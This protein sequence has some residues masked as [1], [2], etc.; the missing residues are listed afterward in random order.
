MVSGTR[1]QLA[2][3]IVVIIVCVAAIA[4][5]SQPSSGG[6]I[7]TGDTLRIGIDPTQPPFAAIINNE[8]VGFEVDLANAIANE[9]GAAVQFVIVNYDSRYDALINDQVD[10]VIATLV[11]DPSKMADVRYSQPYYDD[12]LLLVS[13]D[14]IAGEFDN[15]LQNQTVAF[16]YGSEADSVTRRWQVRIEGLERRPYEL[17]EYALDAIQLGEADA[18]LVDATTFHLYDGNENLYSDTITSVPYSIA[19]PKERPGLA[20]QI[21]DILD[22]LRE[23][24]TLE[25]LVGT[26]F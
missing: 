4:F 8:F 12:G 10:C 25:Q 20:N 9:L 24:G 18:A 14:Q 19:T 2:G 16:A 21:N 26:W 22:Q 5:A 23:D 17:A 13:S 7:Q 6:A 1:K 3:I 11:I 15:L